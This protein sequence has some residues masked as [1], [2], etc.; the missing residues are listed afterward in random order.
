MEY[1]GF[2]RRLVAAIID[3]FI[4]YAVTFAISLPFGL[5]VTGVPVDAMRANAIPALIS[6]A[7]YWS[8]FALMESSAKQATP[9][10]LAI[11]LK[12]TDEDG[13][14]ITLGRATGRYVGKYVSSIILLLGFVMAAFTARKRALHDI[15][16][17]TLV[18]VR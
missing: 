2:S 4:L 3:G 18:V 16:A 7:V 5:S 14:R 6:V 9:G 15:L 12:V 10:K 1:A 8:Y 13:G 17:G 11:S